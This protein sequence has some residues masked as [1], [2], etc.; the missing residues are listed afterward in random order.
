MVLVIE[1]GIPTAFIIGVAGATLLSWETFRG[2]LRSLI[3][4]P[5][6]SG[7]KWLFTHFGVLAAL[8]AWSALC[9]ANQIFPLPYWEIWMWVRVV[10]ELL[11]LASWAVAVLPPSF[12]LRWFASGPS[13]FVGRP[14]LSSPRCLAITPRHYGGCS[15]A[16]RS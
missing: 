3:A 12:W 6:A 9:R 16:R 13:A 8:L 5:G 11:A 2:A 1:K 14:L 10:L 7:L 4:E 15:R